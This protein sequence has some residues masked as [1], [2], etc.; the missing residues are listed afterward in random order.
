MWYALH[1]R[2]RHEKVVAS[3]L[4]TKG[5]ETF[6]PLYKVNRIWQTSRRSV[7]LPLFSSYVFCNFDVTLRSAVLDTPGV[8]SIVGA[9]R[10]PIPVD[11]AELDSVR[12]VVAS[13]HPISPCDYVQSGDAV[14]I[15]HGPLAG[16]QGIV[17]SVKSRQ[18]LVVSLSL[19]QRSVAV[20]MD[21]VYVQLCRRATA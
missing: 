5:F 1:V 2:A 4:Q 6:L 15:E 20:E 19:L 10:V 16:I 12:T 7:E 13:G 17:A 3:L 18:R 14:V 11:A 21:S 8:V 9:G